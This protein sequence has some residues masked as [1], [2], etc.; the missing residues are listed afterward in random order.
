MCQF[1]ILCQRQY[2]LFHLFF[3][4]TQPNQ[5][6]PVLR[7]QSWISGQGYEKPQAITPLTLDTT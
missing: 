6:W 2:R 4:A 3:K 5:L 7:V 1:V